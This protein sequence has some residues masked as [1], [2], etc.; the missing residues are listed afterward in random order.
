[1]VSNIHIARRILISTKLLY[2]CC[3]SIK[4]RRK[5][6]ALIQ[7]PCYWTIPLIILSVTVFHFINKKKVIPISDRSRIANAHY[8]LWIFTNLWIN[9]T[10]ETVNATISQRNARISMPY[11]IQTEKKL[12]SKS[13]RAVWTF[14]KRKHRNEIIQFAA[15]DKRPQHRSIEDSFFTI[16]GITNKS[17]DWATQWFFIPFQI[18]NH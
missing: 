16:A 12:N 15:C 5:S 17:I 11:K 9:E 18:Q 1:M 2:A 13:L 8:F 3:Y 10:V 7:F 4:K 14:H 6:I